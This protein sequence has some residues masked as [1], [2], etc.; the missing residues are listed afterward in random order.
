M[1]I[2]EIC[3]L[4][5]K[6]LVIQAVGEGK[7]FSQAFDWLKTIYEDA[8]QKPV[9]K[10]TL[11]TKYYRAKNAVSNETPS[12]TSQD[13]EETEGKSSVSAA[14]ERP[15]C[16]CGRHRVSLNNRKRKDGLPSFLSKCWKCRKEQATVNKEKQGSPE[17]RNLDKE[18]I[19]Y[20]AE[21]WQKI[22]AKLHELAEFMVQNCEVPTNINGDLRLR[23]LNSLD[24]IKIFLK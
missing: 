16:S 15:F 22:D 23:I 20:E 5:V 4:E 14:T 12:P 13:H 18:D 8:L 11:K 21:V 24:T 19:K 10:A 9:S 7:N 2:S 1:A 3:E 17:P 6:D